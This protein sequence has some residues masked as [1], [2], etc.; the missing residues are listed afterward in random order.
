[1]RFLT[2]SELL[3][4]HRLMLERSGGATG[5]RDP[6]ALSSAAAQPRMAF[7]GQDLY[8]SLP[9]K[10]SALAFSIIRNHPFVDGNKR[11]GHAAMETFLLLNDSELDAT[12]DDQERVI[13]GVAAGDVGRDD[14]TMWVQAHTKPKK[15]G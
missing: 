3:E 5:L 4:L 14:F 12:A 10:A 7:G 11:V 8:P 9:D 1:M 2:V 6:D 13:L 15:P